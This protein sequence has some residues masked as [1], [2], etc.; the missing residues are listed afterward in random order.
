[1][2]KLILLGLYL[3]LS[4]TPYKYRITGVV[5]DV[6]KNNLAGVKVTIVGVYSVYTDYDGS[7]SIKTDSDLPTINLSYLD[8]KEVNI[9][10]NL[11]DYEKKLETLTLYRL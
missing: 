10:L 4:A 6:E 3:L 5:K 7:F 2:N 9:P 11:V 1:M 8:Y